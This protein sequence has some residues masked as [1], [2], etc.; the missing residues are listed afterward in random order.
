MV[1][2]ASDSGELTRFVDQVVETNRGVRF[3]IDRNFQHEGH[4]MT[5]YAEVDGRYGEGPLSS[6][7]FYITPFFAQRPTRH[8]V[9]SLLADALASSEY[10]DGAAR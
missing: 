10:R 5:G 8:Q 7:R 6:P 9:L 3:W 4:G 2:E 1:A